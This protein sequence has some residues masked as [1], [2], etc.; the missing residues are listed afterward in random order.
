M[1]MASPGHDMASIQVPLPYFPSLLYWENGSPRIF[2]AG[3][4]ADE[5]YTVSLASYSWLFDG[6][7]G[8]DCQTGLSWGSLAALL[9]P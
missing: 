6:S 3:R 9:C 2:L 4:V 7:D 5:G 1:L 8:L